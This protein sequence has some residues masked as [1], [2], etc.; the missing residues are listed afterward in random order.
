MGFEIQTWMIVAGAAGGLL[1]FFVVIGLILARFYQRASADEA[2]VRTG[3]GGTK[4]VIGGGIL[5]LPVIH[6]IMRVSLRTVTLTVKR[7]NKQ[8]L[9]T[10]DKI[11]AQCTMELYIR[12][13]NSEDAIKLAAQSF[14]ARNVEAGVLSEIVE[15]KLTDALRGVAAVQDFSDLHSKREE[16]AEAVKKALTEELAKNGLKLESTSLTDLSQLPVAQMDP[17]DVHDAVGLQ[18]ITETVAEAQQRTNLLQKNKEVTIQKQ[19]VEARDTSLQLEKKRAELEATQTKQVAEFQATQQAAEKIAI[20][21]KEQESKEA[22]LEQHRA[23]EAA[24]IAQEQAV[25]ERDLLRQQAVAEAEATKQEAERTAQIRAAKSIEAAQ[26]EKTQVVEAAE[27][28]KKKVIETAEIAKQVAVETA[29]IEK[30]V[31]LAQ[32]D[33]LKAE[34]E[35]EKAGAEALETAARES[36][37]TA[38]EKAIAERLKTIE[39]IEAEKEAQ[40]S[41]IDAEREAHVAGVKA[42]ADLV[43]AQQQAE[44]TKASAEGQANA[45]REQAN[46]AA[47]KVR[48]AAHASK[49]AATEE[50]EA[51]AVRVR[52]AAEAKAG[53][54]LVRAEAEATAATLDAEAKIKLAEATLK[55]GESQAEARRLMVE[56]E[57]V[58]DN[59]ILMLRAAER[60]IDKAP[61]VVREFVKSAEAI[62]EMKVV[63][64]NGLGGLGGEGGEGFS[65]L[66]STPLGI[67]LTTLAQAAAVSP[68]IKGLMSAGGIN[69]EDLSKAVTEKVKAVAKAGVAEFASPGNNRLPAETKKTKSRAATPAE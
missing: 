29:E 49:D 30:Q 42:K 15:G 55:E 27:I 44:A 32:A 3:Q 63:Q 7:E 23:V 12:V 4:V 61:E 66:M 52:V 54:V 24:R 1:L 31:S 57:N 25:T 64:I 53:A 58:V 17:N 6:Q 47:D 8:A 20:L 41:K 33:K 62:G 69:T 45:V 68:V 39:I 37:K 18:N 60:A 22:E 38:S 56:A 11:K 40:R 19:N 51:E 14:G 13:D 28:A 10:K 46:A 5:N 48:A 35:A 67:G 21:A 59:R 16:F 26:I 36:I 50:A 2:I 65:G 34:A 9:V 43:V